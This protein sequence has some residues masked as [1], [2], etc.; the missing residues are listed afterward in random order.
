MRIFAIAVMALIGFFV[1]PVK[2]VVPEYHIEGAGTGNQGTYLVKVSV[3]SKKAK[4]VTD[5]MIGRSA[6]HGVL[7]KGFANKENRQSQKPLAKSAAVEAQHAEF[8]D[9]FFKEGGNAGNYVEVVGSSRSVKKVGKQYQVSATVT[10][11]KEQLRKDL[12]DAG[13]LKGLN[14]YF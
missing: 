3:V 10:V 14:S 6:V 9:E 7:F 11:N 8:F 2:A 12:E 5:E 1:N 13:V 4:D